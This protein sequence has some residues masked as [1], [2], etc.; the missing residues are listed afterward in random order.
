[1]CAWR[2]MPRAVRPRRRGG[3]ADRPARP[4][5]ATRATLERALSRRAALTGRASRPGR[6]WRRQRAACC[7]WSHVNARAAGGSSSTAK[8]ASA[9]A[10][11]SVR[12]QPAPTAAI[13]SVAAGPDAAEHK[14]A[15]AHIRIW[16]V[17]STRA[18]RL[19]A[20]ISGRTTSTA[21]CSDGRKSTLGRP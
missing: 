16:H 5:R 3:G 1:M 11:T 19:H 12:F 20:A 15:R 14:P 18:Q 4:R 13:S 10:R 6:C 21:A 9:L 17:A 8:A 2:Y 7:C